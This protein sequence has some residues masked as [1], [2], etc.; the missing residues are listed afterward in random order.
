[1]LIKP[2]SEKEKA[3]ALDWHTRI[4][5]ERLFRMER[6]IRLENGQAAAQ[7]GTEKKP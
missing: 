2:M 5:E 6:L 3:E 4:Y 7:P 1:M